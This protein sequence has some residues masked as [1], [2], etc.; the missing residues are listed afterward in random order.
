[1]TRVYSIILFAGALLLPAVLRAE[2]IE[3]MPDAIVCSVKDPTGT[4]SWDRLVYY[5]SAHMTSGETLY[6][7]LTSD[8]VVLL[9]SSDG[10]INGPNLADCDGRSVQALREEGRAF[11]ITLPP[12]NSHGTD[13]WHYA[14]CRDC[15]S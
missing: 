2:I 10:I 5:V 4:L 12:A 3:N 9:V 14:T 6:K 11:D 15:F 1:V 8:P 7:T 13:R